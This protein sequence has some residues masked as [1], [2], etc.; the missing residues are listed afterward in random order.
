MKKNLAPLM[1]AALAVGAIVLV[2]GRKLLPILEQE[3]AKQAPIVSISPGYP[4]NRHGIPTAVYGT[5]ACPVGEALPGASAGG[6]VENGCILL[7]PGKIHVRYIERDHVVDDFWDVSVAGTQT[8]AR[9]SD[10]SFV[11][12]WEFKS[13]KAGG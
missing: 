1:V 9:W 4:V 5:D 2:G 11:M 3:V 7:R 12:P 8:V 6:S 13:E 10:G